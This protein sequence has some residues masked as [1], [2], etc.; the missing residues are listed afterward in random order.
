MNESERFLKEEMMDISK[1]GKKGIKRSKDGRRTIMELLKNG[2]MDLFELQK[3]YMDEG[4]D[5]EMFDRDLDDL[6][7]AGEVIMP[8]ETAVELLL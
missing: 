7:K 1:G 5:E 4:F 2:P 6:R 3:K 8:N